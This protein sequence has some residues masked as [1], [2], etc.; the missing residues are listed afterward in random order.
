M[1]KYKGPYYWYAFG[2]IMCSNGGYD[3]H[4]LDGLYTSFYDN[5]NL[6]EK[7]YFRKGLKRGMWTEWF[8]N[9]KIKERSYWRKGFRCGLTVKYNEEGNL[10]AEENYN[11]GAYNGTVTRYESGQIISKIFYKNG[12]EYIPKLAKKAAD[13]TS[14]EDAIANNQND[15]NTKERKNKKN[16]FQ[17]VKELFS[18]KKK[19]DINGTMDSANK[20]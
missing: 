7:G 14:R 13:S 18:R 12:L 8:E 17:K 15:S 3:G 2:K 1:A 5:N 11:K 6:K 9:G 19:D 4:V 16:L 20:P 10:D